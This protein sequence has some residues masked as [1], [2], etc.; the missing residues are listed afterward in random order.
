MYTKEIRPFWL[1]VTKGYNFT[2]NDIDW[3]CPADLQPYADAH[4]EEFAEKDRIAWMN[5]M[6]M[7]AAIMSSIGNA[8][9]D[10]GQKANEYP[11]E[12]MMAEEKNTPKYDKNGDMILTEEE[13]KKWRERLL[14]GLQVKQ[15]NFEVSKGGMVS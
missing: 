12:P 8:F 2:V 10:K 9:L 11:E 1:F 4:R 14:L 7:R 5:G 13:K 3:S 6:Y 15:H